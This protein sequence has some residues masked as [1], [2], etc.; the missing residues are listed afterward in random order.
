M[1]LDR[2]Q[3]LVYDRS[4]VN[5]RFNF[6]NGYTMLTL[7]GKNR[8]TDDVEP[9]VAGQG[10]GMK[11]KRPELGSCEH[12]TVDNVKRMDIEEQ[13]NIGLA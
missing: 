8:P 11:V 4:G 1:I 13:I 7:A 9:S 2:E 6:V 10:T 12:L 3:R 5:R